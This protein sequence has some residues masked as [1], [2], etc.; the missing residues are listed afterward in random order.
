MRCNIYQGE[1]LI[2]QNKFFR[3]IIKALSYCDVICPQKY[4]NGNY[5]PVILK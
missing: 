5:Y 2:E 4:G 1:R 3:S